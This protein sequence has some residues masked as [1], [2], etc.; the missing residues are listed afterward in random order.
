MPRSI[1]NGTITFGMVNVPI[2]LYSAVES[3]AVH[4][5]EVHVKDGAQIE[6]RRICPKE[7]KEVPYKQIVKGYEVAPD[8]YVV[9]DKEEIK[10]AAGDRGK[11]VHLEEFV[12]VAEIDPVFY[13]K[14]YYLG[15]RV[16]ADVYRLLHDALRRSGR[17]GIGRFTFQA[18]ERAGRV[19]LG[20]LV[21]RTKEY[22]VAVRTR[23][24]ALAL[25]TMLFHDEIRSSDAIDTGGKKPTKKALGNALA[26]IEELST[27]WNP[28]SYTDCYRERLGGVID[29]KRKGARIR[30]PK[31]QREPAPAPDLMA[32]LQRTVERVRDGGDARAAREAA[33]DGGDELERL[34]REELY[35]R[36]QEAG[37]P[38]RSKMSKAELV[39]ALG[40]GD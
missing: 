22:L 28:G 31:P 23:E 12:E 30:A 15:P 37:M 35:R 16:D 33:G 29:R 6:H 1:W 4:F 14:T 13:E 25:T 8:E 36:A 7:E 2:K 32:A 11:V 10:A 38:G 24:G 27:D 3:K 21:M 34:D 20:R 39:E 40:D 19:A 17:A 5:S 26:I 9:L 18:M